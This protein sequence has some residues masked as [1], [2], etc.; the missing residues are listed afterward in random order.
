MQKK[1]TL[2]Y[3][4]VPEPYKLLLRATELYL[5]K[6]IEC[7]HRPGDRMG[8]VKCSMCCLVAAVRAITGKRPS[9]MSRRWL[10]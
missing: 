3:G 1:Q 10:Y 5:E 7:G 9:Q 2:Q 8:G 4:S 6:K